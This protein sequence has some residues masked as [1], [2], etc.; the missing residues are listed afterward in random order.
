MPIR[1]ILVGKDTGEA[2]GAMMGAGQLEGIK[3][4]YIHK[5]LRTTPFRDR[6]YVYN[7]AALYRHIVKGVNCYASSL[8]FGMLKCRYP[9]EYRALLKESFP[10]RYERE[11]G[12]RKNAAAETRRQRV[13]KRKRVRLQKKE[14][15]A[16]RK[17]AV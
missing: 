14:W 10:G 9:R 7:L 16:A 11:F 4:A 3:S 2:A 1:A 5:K 6:A 15:R 12:W 13:E 8:A 17:G